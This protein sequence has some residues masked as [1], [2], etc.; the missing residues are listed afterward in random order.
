MYGGYVTIS[1][2]HRLRVPKFDEEGTVEN[3][4]GLSLEQP[5]QNLAL[6]VL[7]VPNLLHRVSETFEC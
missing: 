5:D 4:F 3:D 6:T 7:Y 2:V 1:G